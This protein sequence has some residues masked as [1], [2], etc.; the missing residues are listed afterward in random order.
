MY[1]AAILF[2]I[3]AFVE[4][5]WS[6]HTAIPFA[7]KIAVGVA[8]WILLASYFAFGGRARAAG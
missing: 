2:L 4:A 5:F 1:G 7:A 6:P 8:G 3:A